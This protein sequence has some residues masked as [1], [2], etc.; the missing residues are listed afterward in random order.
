[1]KCDCKQC[2]TYYR[3]HKITLQEHARGWQAEVRGKYL[4]TNDILA[5]EDYEA[6][7]KACEEIDSRMAHL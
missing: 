4:F 3:G 5:D 6:H 7:E 2:P 1:M